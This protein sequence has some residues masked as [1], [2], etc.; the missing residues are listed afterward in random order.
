MVHLSNSHSISTFLVPFPYIL[1]IT[2]MGLKICKTIFRHRVSGIRLYFYLYDFLFCPKK[3]KKRKEKTREPLFW[4]LLLINLQNLTLL[5]VSLHHGLDT[6]VRLQSLAYLFITIA[7][8][9]LFLILEIF[10]VILA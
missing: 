5:D 7:L 4:K 2:A 3:G 9:S 10:L 6:S 8:V 1:L